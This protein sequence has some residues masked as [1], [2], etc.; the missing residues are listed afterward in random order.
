MP[1]YRILTARK[2]IFF[3][4]WFLCYGVLDQ[5]PSGVRES[6]FNYLAFASVTSISSVRLGAL[7]GEAFLGKG[8][9]HSYL[10]S[11]M[12]DAKR[13]NRTQF[14]SQ[15]L[16]RQY[17]QKLFDGELAPREVITFRR[18]RFETDFSIGTTKSPEEVKKDLES[19]VQGML[20]VLS[21][22]FTVSYTIQSKDDKVN[23]ENKE[24]GTFLG[25][26]RLT[27]KEKGFFA[28]ELQGAFP[29]GEKELFQRT[30]YL[31]LYASE[32]SEKITREWVSDFAE[33]FV[34]ELVMALEETEEV[35]I[36]K[37]KNALESYL[38]ESIKESLEKSPEIILY[39]MSEYPS[40]QEQFRSQLKDF[41]KKQ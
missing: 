22:Q 29:I 25:Q 41:L 32:V 33:T 9:E 8:K 34:Q 26:I 20:T 3:A 16:E 27:Q 17:I 15:M 40:T 10:E 28:V 38:I 12:Q 4:V 6:V 31:D 11:I 36:Q 2:I 30:S 1:S 14:E 24:F 19:V 5:L 21:Y 35:I 7:H 39:M 13:L 18:E 37:F 23:S